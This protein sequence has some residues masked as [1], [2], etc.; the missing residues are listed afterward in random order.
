MKII[1]STK[2]LVKELDLSTGN[3]KILVNVNQSR[4]F[5]MAYDYKYGYIFLPRYELGDILRY[6]FQISLFFKSRG[7]HSSS[8]DLQQEA[9]LKIMDGI[10]LLAAC[11]FLL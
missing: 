4:V 2:G 1:F 9:I 7:K 8:K 10:N 5:S 3:V 6:E 11:F